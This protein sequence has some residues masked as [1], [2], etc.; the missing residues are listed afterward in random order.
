MEWSVCANRSMTQ[1][2]P[3]MAPDEISIPAGLL[4]NFFRV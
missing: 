3:K 2:K 4:S 1:Q